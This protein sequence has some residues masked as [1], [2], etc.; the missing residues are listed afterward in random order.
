MMLRETAGGAMMAVGAVLILGRN[1]MLLV[2]SVPSGSPHALA[3]LTIIMAVVVLILRL[4][5]TAR[6]WVVWPIP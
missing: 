1:D 5:R 3:A 4:S 2:Y 6:S